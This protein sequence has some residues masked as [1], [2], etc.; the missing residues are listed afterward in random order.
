MRIALLSLGFGL[1]ATTVLAQGERE[2]QRGQRAYERNAYREAIEV[3]TKIRGGDE[4]YAEAQYWLARAYLMVDPPMFAEAKAAARIAYNAERSND[5]YRAL[6]LLLSRERG[7][8]FLP[9]FKQM[10]MEVIARRILRR[11]STNAVAHLV[12][13]A[14]NAQ[15]YTFAHGSVSIKDDLSQAGAS[16]VNEK[17]ETLERLM[18]RG[19]SGGSRARDGLI[20]DVVSDEIMEATSREGVAE[21]RYLR[22]YAFLLRA[23]ELD[24]TLRDPYPELMRVIAM[25]GR[26][27]DAEP[28]LDAMAVHYEQTSDYWLYRGMVAV[29]LDRYEQAE[30]A[31]AR[32]KAYLSDEEWRAFN[33]PEAFYDGEEPEAHAAFWASQDP[34]FLTPYNERL[35][36]HYARLVYADLRFGDMY[37]KYRGWETEPGQVIVRYGRPRIEINLQ[38]RFDRALSFHYD[39]TLYFRFMDLSKAGKWIFYSPSA[40]TFSNQPGFDMWNADHTLRSKEIF[41]RY[42]DRIEEDKLESIPFPYLVNRLRGM[43]SRTELWVPVGVVVNTSR[44]TPKRGA[45][46]LL[47]EDRGIVAQT[48]ELA[49][50]D[51]RHTERLYAQGTLYVDTYTLSAEPGAYEMAVEFE[52]QSADPLIAHNR[53]EVDVPDYTGDDLAASDLVLAY[54]IEERE[55]GTAAQGAV[56]RR[57]YQLDLAPWGVFGIGQPLYLYYELYNLSLN[58]Q[59]EGLYEVEAIIENREERRRVFGRDREE[60]VSVRT[61]QRITATDVGDFLI[62]DTSD[63]A[64]GL[65][66]VRVLVRD[67]ESGQ[68]VEM[69]RQI[70][71]E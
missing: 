42:P 41:A 20:R 40:S 29:E 67:R 70:R 24:P 58:A 45:V 52:V 22:A 35:L 36:I 57:G 7:N 5:D 31:F 39:D 51:P 28:L 16:L 38:D 23:A 46:T 65:Y 18:T 17:G 55:V 3:F 8:G 63:Q 15:D 19:T 50:L 27:S 69:E 43:D 6:S 1:L 56:S 25:I 13:G 32:A 66:T 34:R 4:K 9:L 14:R 49:P 47:N 2:F 60:A 26:Y 30:Q 12:I 71:L 62:L 68:Q 37:T 48:F 21:R 61:Q 53:T 11:D 59:G 44:R 10:R 64:P 33:T 54:L